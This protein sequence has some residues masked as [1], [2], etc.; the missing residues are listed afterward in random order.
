MGSKTFERSKEVADIRG[1]IDHPIIDGDGHLIEF[2]PWLRDLIVDT[3]DESVAKQFDTLVHGSAAIRG[4]PEDARRELGISR[5]SYWALPARNTLDRAT[6]MLPELLYD[7]LDEI[8][9][10]FALL[11]PT[12]GLTVV[13]IPAPSFGVRW[14]AP[15]TAT[16]PRRTIP[17]ATGLS[18]LRQSRCSP[19]TKRSPSSIMQLAS[20][21]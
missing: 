20:S 6:A 5:S 16:S 3:A 4:V 9:I 15:V 10:D 11:Y 8:G 17:T 7:R 1:Q 21:G 13:G 19:L 2:V 14:L 12:Y 18:R